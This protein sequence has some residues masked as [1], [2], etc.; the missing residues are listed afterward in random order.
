MKTVPASVRRL[1]EEFSRLPGVGPKSA[2][3][4]TFHLLRSGDPRRID[5]GQAVLDLRAGVVIC[6]TCCNLAESDPCVLCGDTARDKSLICVVE[7][8]LDIVAL[9]KGG[10]YQ[11]LYHVLG[12]ALSPVDGI[13]PESL[14]VAPL[15][16]RIDDGGVSEIILATNHSL[17]GEATAMYL[18]RLIMPK[19]VTVTRIAQGLPM[20]ADLEYADQ[21]TLA[22]ALE[23]RR[24]YS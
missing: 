15:V 12:G 7:Q 18:S 6:S 3:R 8:P 14:S 11:G 4:L 19:G 2:E 16:K 21:V 10:G 13:G 9:E 22:R 17:E 20:G 1:I 24:S 5:L 23:G